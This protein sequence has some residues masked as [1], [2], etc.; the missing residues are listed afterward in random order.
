M[1]KSGI[2][3][4]EL[5]YI[6]AS[7]GHTDR[8]V[9]CDSGLPIGFRERVVD[10]ALV[11]NIPGFVDTLQAVMRELKIER[12]IIAEEMEKVNNEIYKQVAVL[13]EGI[14][15]VK[16]PHEEFKA[17]T[18]ENGNISFVRTGEATPFANII[19]V[20]GVTFD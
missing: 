13:M 20:S 4:A 12:A 7:M 14:E 11:E 9:I 15:L 6:I 19:L 2:L 18:S 3:N 17:M 8:L 16:I 1:K 10:L 5:S